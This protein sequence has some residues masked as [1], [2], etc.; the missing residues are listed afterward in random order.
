[1][2]HRGHGEGSVYKRKS[3]GLWAASISVGGGTRKTFYG[4]TRKEVQAKLTDALQALKQ[5]RAIGD[6][7]QPF[8]MFLRH[9]LDTVKRPQ[10]RD[11]SYRAYDNYARRITPLIGHIRLGDLRASHIQSAYSE[12]ES[13]LSGRTIRT[14]HYMLHQALRQAMEWELIGRNHAEL[15]TL[16]RVARHDASTFTVEQLQQLFSCNRQTR[17]Y[18][19]WLLLASTGMRH[20]EAM[21]LKWDSIDWTART[22]VVR[23]T[24]QWKK[25]EGLLLHEP[26]TSASRR[27]IHLTSEVLDS[28]SEHQTRQ[29]RD[30]DSEGFQFHGFV[31]CSHLG[32]PF[33]PTDVYRAW[34][35]ALKCADLP[36]IR[37]HDLRHTAAT[38]LLTE[39]IHPRVAQEML[40][41]HSVN[42]TL[43]VY[44]HV[45]PSMHK[46]AAM[47]LGDVLRRSLDTPIAAIQQEDTAQADPLPKLAGAGVP[48]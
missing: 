5:G 7:R 9:W 43:S 38:L 15:V 16:P 12:L 30:E 24:L 10:V 25:G 4:K 32:T 17:W 48:S 37:I 45:L 18:P 21:A 47:R 36:H 1:M 19:L 2:G 3:D 39:G 13:K 22:L 8:G 26:K 34:N 31:F 14:I 27:T 20:G 28:L 33:Y 11:S 35:H 6:S 44:S 41:H 23:H 29:H 42:I 40:G 46:E